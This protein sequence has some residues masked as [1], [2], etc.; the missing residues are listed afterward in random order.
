[1]TFWVAGAAVVGAVGS[2][3]IKGNAAAR[4]S[5]AQV[6]GAEAGID[7]Q[8]R[9]FDVATAIMAPYTDAGE[10]A[11]TGLKPYVDVGPEALAQQRV[12]AGLEGPEKQR[13]AI[14]AL[15]ANPEFQALSRQGEEAMLQ[16]A[17]ATGG[18]RGG[19]IQGALAQYR[20]QMLQDY[21][22]QQYGR[23]GGLTSL[24]QLTSQNIAALGQASAAGQAANALETGKNIAGLYGDIGAAR[25]AK[26]G[27]QGQM[28]SGILDS[29]LKFG[30]SASGKW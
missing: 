15:A 26:F 24:G 7:E 5:R 8:R 11:L 30:G 1:M 20:P 16:N 13:E 29:A 6:Q 25:A 17:S 28:W 9:Q 23:L 27:A 4:A 19:N 21:I 14:N 3:V 10:E 2:S 12:L 18:L 22:T